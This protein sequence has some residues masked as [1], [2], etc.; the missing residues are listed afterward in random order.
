MEFGII[1]I[2]LFALILFG[3][4]IAYSIGLSTALF[5]TVT[6]MKPLIVLSQRSVLGMDSFVLLAIP[7]FTLSGYLM[8]SG[9]LSKRLID[10]VEKLFGWIPGSMGTITI[11][12]CTL[13]AALTGSGPATVAAI[14]ALMIPSMMKAGYTRSTA[15][16]L[17]AAGGA[18][19][20]IIPPSIPIIVY[21]CTM[22]VSV[23]KLFMAGILPGILLA[24]LFI[25]TNTII[26]LR[27]GIKAERIK[28]TGK[29]VLISLW[30]ALGVLLLPVIILGGIY[31]GFFTPTEAATVCVIYSLILGL[32]F[33][34]LSFERFK[35]AMT[36][37]IQTSAMVVFIVGMSN[38]FGWTLAV[39][40]I[41]AKIANAVIPYLNNRVSYLIILML[42]L[43]LVGCIME[44]L[45][46]IVILGPI[47]VPIGIELGINPV[48][49]GAV[50]CVCL[51][52]GF[53]TPP[54]GLN[55]FTAA[56]TANTSFSEVVR[57]V[58]P[59]LIAAAIA[60]VVIAFVP[61]ISL[62]FLGA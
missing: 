49:L 36:R 44:T 59:F 50:F 15:S 5:L 32:I 24:V 17:L 8:E 57:G 41:P 1:F 25:I 33:K 10:C 20:P 6:H 48:H 61:Q 43:F 54:F 22:S 42:I 38:C 35:D 31:G 4:P 56:S 30:K 40:K 14:G 19:G 34:E 11:I 46:S 21:G 16:G 60:V 62:A 26:A 58:W 45:S 37:T 27:V 9:G 47:L 7:L 12:C 3:V 55:L 2:A 52:V 13:F 29:E 39:A 23:P 28:Y 18:L 51:V 53:I